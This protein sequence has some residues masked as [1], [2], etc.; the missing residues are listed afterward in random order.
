MKKVTQAI[1]AQM[2]QLRESGCSMKE[3]SEITGLCI[4]TVSRQTKSC[5]V[6]PVRKPKAPVLTDRDKKMMTLREQGHSYAE[7]GEAVGMS[8][9]AVSAAFYS[10]LR[11]LMP[12]SGKII[13]VRKKGGCSEGFKPPDDC[14]NCTNDD[15]NYNGPVRAGE[16]RLMKLGH[17]E[18]PPECESD[19]LEDYD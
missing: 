10:K 18:S 12:N 15:C 19:R 3:I 7:I 9:T 6:N 13:R 11:K 8:K 5:T 2:I 4:K 17:K 16:N 1:K 14:F